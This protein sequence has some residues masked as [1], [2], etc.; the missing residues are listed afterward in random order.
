MRDLLVLGFMALVSLWVPFLGVNIEQRWF[1]GN[2]LYYLLPIP[3][4][5]GLLFLFLW[6][7]L[8][9]DDGK[10][11]W[12]PF[13]LALG[14][15]FMGYVGLAVSLWPNIVPYDVTI[16]QAAAAPESLSLMLV[17]VAIMLPVILAYTGWC[18]Y[19]FRGKTDENHGY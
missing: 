9:R 6:I 18:Y 7:G 3:V 13:L 16:W 4:M 12:L 19:I 11:D 8:P 2:N 17:G 15:F 1:G 10:R 5:T 14:I